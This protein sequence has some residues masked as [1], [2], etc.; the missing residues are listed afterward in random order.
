MALAS[1][2]HAS[3]CAALNLQTAKFLVRCRHSFV[4]LA[5]EPSDDQRQHTYGWQ[6]GSGAALHGDVAQCRRRR[7][8][9][10]LL[11][12]VAP[13]LCPY[14][15][16]TCLTLSQTCQKCPADDPSAGDNGVDKGQPSEA[17]TLYDEPEAATLLLAC[18]V[19]LA[20]GA[21][22]VLFNNVIHLIRHIAWSTTPLEATYWGQWARSARI[23]DLQTAASA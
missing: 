15:Q 20:T 18:G 19:G 14:Q 1:P 4:G 13:A 5:I 7:E 21:S 9:Q 8:V 17:I 22:V 6:L 16:A 2:C 11:L 12:P 3:D 10:L 23:K